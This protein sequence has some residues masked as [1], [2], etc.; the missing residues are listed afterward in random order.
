MTIAKNTVRLWYD[1]EAEEASGPPRRLT[2]RLVW[3]DGL[4]RAA[5]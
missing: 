3:T 1:K 2:D 5:A 4:R